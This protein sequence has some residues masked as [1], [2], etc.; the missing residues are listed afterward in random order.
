MDRDN[1]SGV[2]DY[3]VT[4]SSS[5]PQKP[6]PIYYVQAMKVGDPSVLYNSAEEIKFKLNQVVHFVVNRYQALG[7]GMYCVNSENPAGCF[8]YKARFCCGKA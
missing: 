7:V 6:C 8:D 4:D 5:N 2:G 3:E 1:P